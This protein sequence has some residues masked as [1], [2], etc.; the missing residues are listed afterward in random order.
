[1]TRHALLP[2]TLLLGLAAC[3]QPGP[4]IP[5]PYTAAEEGL[6]LVYLNPSLPG[7]EQAARRLQVRVDKVVDREDGALVIFKSFT[8][9]TQPPFQAT[10]VVKGDGVG[11]LSADGR[12][13][14]AILPAGFPD[15]PQTW[16]RGDVAYRILGRAAWSGA[17]SVL[18]EDRR[19]EGGVGTWVEAR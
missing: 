11:L 15:G 18:P 7:A 2:A 4:Q 17:A 6:T 1:M 12:T 13:E 19:A 5:R 3:R 10:F 14:T 16:T 9:G 8:V